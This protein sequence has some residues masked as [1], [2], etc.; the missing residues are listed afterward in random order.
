MVL[1]VPLPTNLPLRTRFGEKGKKF[2]ICGT[3]PVR[4]YWPR[5]SLPAV[6][7][8]GEG[9]WMGSVTTFYALRRTREGPRSVYWFG[10][11]KKIR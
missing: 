11:G 10:E 7:R 8:S 6:A 5:S 4:V 9:G 1:Q 2:L 3:M